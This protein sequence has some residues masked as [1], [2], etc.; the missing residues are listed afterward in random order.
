MPIIFALSRKEEEII[1]GK[2]I[3]HL[4]RPELPAIADLYIRRKLRDNLFTA[5]PIRM[6][7][8]RSEDIKNKIAPY[9]S[10]DLQGE[11]KIFH[12][13]DTRDKDKSQPI[14]VLITYRYRP[15]QQTNI[16]GHK[17]LNISP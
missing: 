15:L 1:T 9:A 3:K 16:F 7:L 2:H 17:N 6:I 5:L 13:G 14:R 8:N 4:V 12:C 10:K 11:K